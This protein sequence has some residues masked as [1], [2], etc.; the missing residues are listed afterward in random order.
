MSHVFHRSAVTLPPVAVGARGIEIVDSLGRRYLD[1]S[2]GAAVSCIGHGDPRV[3]E[4]ARQAMATLDYA[5]TGFFTSE[6]AEQLADFL[7]A[8]T[9]VPLE[10]VYFVS[11]GSE[12]IE[13]AVKMARQYHLERGEESRHL[14]IAR[15]Q[16]YHGNTLGA[17][18]AGGNAGRRAPYRPL[19]VD[20]PKAA[21]CF[22][23]HHRLPEE[24]LADYAERAADSLEAEILHAGPEN[25]MAF[26]AETVVG[27]TTGAVPPV[28]GYFKRIREICDRY[29][30]L[31]ILDEVMCGAGRC[32]TFLACEQEGIHP[33]IVTL[34]KGLGGGYLPIAAVLCTAEVYRVFAEGSGGFVHGHTY[35]AH[36]VACATALAVQQVVRDE[37]LLRNVRAQ[38]QRLME[39]LTAR[40]GNH[41][42]VGDIRG[43]GLLQAIELV[44]HRGSK[45]PFD[46]A[47]KTAARIQAEAMQRGLLVYP[48]AGTL[49]GLRGDHILVAPPYNVDEAGLEEIVTRLGEAVD[50]ALGR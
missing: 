39:R 46:P 45:T 19:L 50:A 36:P 43:R 23:Y 30:V 9:P 18:A 38:G 47:G 33:D 28:P 20:G 35:G 42:F 32:G 26:V 40:F 49:D 41:P 11:S 12:A 29:G 7:C 13:A 1:A 4:A 8:A 2:G 22:E 6:A 44:E 34:A 27:A 31:L 5:H 15:Q 3:V 16:S 25:V 17:L 10:R 24:S 21:P 37:D 48:G 14:V